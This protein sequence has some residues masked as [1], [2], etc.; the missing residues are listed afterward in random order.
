MIRE[1]QQE[2]Y[3]RL[4]NKPE[5]K[6]SA[7]QTSIGDFNKDFD[8]TLDFFSSLEKKNENIELSNT[9]NNTLK[10]YPP[11]HSTSVPTVNLEPEP[12]E[13]SSIKLNPHPKYGCLKNGSLPTFRSWQNTMKNREPPNPPT[14][15]STNPPTNPSTNPPTNPSTNPSIIASPSM[16]IQTNPIVKSYITHSNKNHKRIK[17]LKRKKIYKRTYRVGKNKQKPNISVLISNKT[18]R[19]RVSTEAQL[20]KQ[21]PMNEVRKFLIKKGFIKIG[22]NTPNDVLRKIFE[23]VS[24]ICGE[25]QNHNSDNLLF[26]F[27]NDAS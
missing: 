25:I 26:N 4:F 12:V 23:T 13:T 24:M 7:K 8:E 2:E 16:P 9:H 18:I 22:T 27:I 1:K 6:V 3:K 11:I 20:L 21:T 17:Y 5:K 19:N 10:Q 14:N 15:P